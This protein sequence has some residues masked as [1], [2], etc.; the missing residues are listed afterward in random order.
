KALA[1][2]DFNGD[3]APDLILSNGS[4]GYN[5]ESIL[6]NQAAA[7][8]LLV[9]PSTATPGVGANFNVTVSAQ[10]GSGSYQNYV[11]TVTLTS[12]DPL[13][14]TLGSHTFTAADHGS[15]TFT[16]ALPSA[17]LHT[18][19]ATDGTNTN[20]AQVTVQNTAPQLSGVQ[21]MP[22]PVNQ[23]QQAT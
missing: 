21:I 14:P 19:T 9:T 20:S 3:G 18:I 6:L 11:G 12:D 13:A 1:S 22:S 17:G 10:A 7:T 4:G 23:G 2:G 15:Y 5:G 16:V 8:G